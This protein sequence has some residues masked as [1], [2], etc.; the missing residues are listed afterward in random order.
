MKHLLPPNATVTIIYW[1]RRA[2][3]NQFTAKLLYIFTMT[4]QDTLAC[5]EMTSS[6]LK[7]TKFSKLTGKYFI[8]WAIAKYGA[9]KKR[10]KL[11]S[12]SRNI[13]P[14]L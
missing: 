4:S 9:L 14:R 2:T 11:V 13:T 10:W 12:R 3:V 7:A 5:M 8:K 6:E 1:I